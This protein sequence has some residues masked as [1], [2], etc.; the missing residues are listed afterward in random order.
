M[1]KVDLTIYNNYLI[2]FQLYDV[3]I[4]ETNYGIEK[5]L[6][7]VEI[8]PSTYRKCKKGELIA[9]PKLI[10]K[11]TKYFEYKIPNSEDIKSFE[12]LFNIIY[13][14]MYYKIYDNYEHYI[15]KM[16]EIIN[17]KYAIFPIALLF[18]LLLIISSNIDYNT[19]VKNNIEDY[20]ILKK[21][22]K[23]FSDELLEIFE[24]IYLAFEYN[25]SEGYWLKNYNN[26]FAYYIL[27]S[28]SYFNQKYI[29]SIFFATK[30]KEFLSNDGNIIRILFLNNILMSSLL[31]VG[32]YQE[33][34]DLAFKQKLTLKAINSEYLFLQ[35]S[36]KKYEIVSLLGLEKFS[37]IITILER[38]QSFNI[39]LLTCYLVS[40]FKYKGKKEYINYYNDLEF[41]EFEKNDQ[42]YLR[43]LNTF[44][45]YNKKS[46]L[47]HLN[48]YEIEGWLINILKKIEIKN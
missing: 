27:A 29:E 7:M 30:S 17:E 8:N 31:Y 1:K 4:N 9:G 14:N 37:E 3:A 6:Q 19:I 24:L 28:R 12:D 43:N 35:K 41:E 18:K 11:L 15:K 39:I 10:E 46:I 32:N 38:S 36:L 44:L 47:Q 2:Y 40:I 42:D 21:Y 33:C 20:K 22:C 25:I 23:F 16:D 45:V 26:G 34:N 5:F 48:H 13:Y